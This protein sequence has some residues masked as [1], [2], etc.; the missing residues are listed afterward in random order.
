ML[1]YAMEWHRTDMQW[2]SAGMP[3]NCTETEILLQE[4]KL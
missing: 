4:E 3:W 2:N 1:R